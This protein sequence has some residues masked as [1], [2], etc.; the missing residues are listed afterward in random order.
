MKEPAAAFGA[1]AVAVE[2]AVVEAL[3]VEIAAVEALVAGIAVEEPVAADTAVDF[4]DTAE[5]FVDTVEEELLELL[6]ADTAV[7]A[8]KNVNKT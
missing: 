2:I 5:G 3:A 1:L 4:V 7:V 6:A 8:S